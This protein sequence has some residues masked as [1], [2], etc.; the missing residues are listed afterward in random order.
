MKPVG[1]ILGHPLLYS[2]VVQCEGHELLK[3]ISSSEGLWEQLGPHHTG[4]GR[5]RG[6]PAGKG[7][8]IRVHS[9]FLDLFQ[10]WPILLP[11]LQR[12]SM[13]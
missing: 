6:G 4:L 2:Q 8:L 9:D 3:Y 11:D 10:P 12:Q 1:A 7:V 13:L 5:F